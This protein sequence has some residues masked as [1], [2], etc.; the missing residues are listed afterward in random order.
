M[1]LLLGQGDPP[2]G[3][4]VQIRRYRAPRPI[5]PGDSVKIEASLVK[6]MGPVFQGRVKATR[7]GRIAASGFFTVREGRL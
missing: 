1:G 2:G 4:V 3:M 6:R 5:H 7:D